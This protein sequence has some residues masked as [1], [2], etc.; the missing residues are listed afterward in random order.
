M[1]LYVYFCEK[2]EKELKAFHS[3]KEKYITCHE[4]DDCELS[5]TL[6]RVPSNFSTK[7]KK[8]DKRK[9]GSIVHEFIENNKEDLKKEKETLRDQEY[10]P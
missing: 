7:I 4:I 10:K 2:C 3:I 1:P 5:G 6:T 9:V 8:E